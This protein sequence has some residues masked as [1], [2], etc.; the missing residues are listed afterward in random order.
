M[1]PGCRIRI[2]NTIGGRSGTFYI[3]CHPEDVPFY[4]QAT[5]ETGFKIGVVDKAVD[6]EGGLV[7]G[8]IA[9]HVYTEGDR[10]PLG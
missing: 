10:S 4:K 5:E 7:K 6:L 2:F 8:Y 3:N 1:L 9:I